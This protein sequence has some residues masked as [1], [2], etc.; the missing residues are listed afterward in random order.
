M[1]V[2]T[3]QPVHCVL[4]LDTSGSMS[5][6]ASKRNANNEMEE[7]SNNLL[8][9][10]KL[11]AK[12]YTHFLGEDDY[13]SVVGFGTRVT[14][15]L[16]PT[17]ATKEGREKATEMI[18]TLDTYGTTALGDGLKAALDLCLK[19]PRDVVRQICVLTDGEP[20]ED[21]AADDVLTEYHDTHPESKGYRIDTFAFGFY[22]VDSS[23]LTD[24]AVRGSG[25]YTYIPDSS[26]V[27]T[28]FVHAAA[29]A[30]CTVATDVTL[31]GCEGGDL[32]LGPVLCGQERSM[33]VAIGEGMCLKYRLPCEPAT[34]ITVPCTPST[35]KPP[36]TPVS[37]S[38]SHLWHYI[39]HTLSTTVLET[40]SAPFVT[41][42]VPEEVTDIVA[43]LASIAE[44]T[45]SE[46]EESGPSVW[47]SKL[48]EDWSSQMAMAF[49]GQYLYKWGLH[50]LLSICLSH[51]REVCNNHKDGS[52]AS[53]GGSL[54]RGLVKDHNLTFNTMPPPKPRVTRY[55]EE[56]DDSDNCYDCT[57]ASSSATQSRPA[58]IRPSDFNCSDGPCVHQE[59][60][61]TLGNGSVCMAQEVVAGTE[62]MVP[63]GGTAK[64][65]H[66]LATEC[67][68]TQT[69]VVLPD[70][71]RITP[72]HPVKEGVEG[73]WVFPIDVD[74]LSTVP[75]GSECRVYSFCLERPAP[76]APRPPA[77]LIDSQV[78]L[79]LG[80]GVTVDAVCAHPFYGTEAVVRG[81]LSLPLVKGQRHLGRGMVVRDTDTGLA[82][83][84]SQ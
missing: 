11:G 38:P 28:A 35:D 47:L 75:C 68:D 32:M 52:L 13:V 34:V 64:V 46:A 71:L 25:Q 31:C 14:V 42:G 37:P 48:Y 77:M 1:K 20:N 36:S 8:D 16:T 51:Q 7:F 60:R 66:V 39:R 18:E 27:G 21:D 84:F 24:L 57:A 62:V 50:Y 4:L 82:C 53:Y 43:A 30:L 72:Y 56:S 41:A 45:P 2:E 65:E 23:L 33:P 54:F 15:A 59:S 29:A 17:R 80:H 69:L 78:V 61:V 22:S 73:P 9:I 3:R 12:A 76:S 81:M 55:D 49:T 63:G 19:G 44:A 67:S 26:F 74:G 10:V 58:Y 6:R 40:M 79:C 70:G 5:D 83:G